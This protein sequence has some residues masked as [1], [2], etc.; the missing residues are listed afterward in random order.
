MRLEIYQID[1]FASAPFTGNPAAVMPLDEWPETALLQKLA[2]ENNLSETAFLVAKAEGRYELRWFTPATEVALCGHATLASAH[3]LFAEKG[4]TGGEIIFETR[5][6]GE[7]KVKKIADERYQMDLPSYDCTPDEKADSDLIAKIL[8]RKPAAILAGEFPLV[9]FDDPAHVKNM[10]PDFFTMRQLKHHEHSGSLLVTAPGEGQYDF[11][12]RFFAPGL[13]IEE[14]PVTGSAHCQL[15]P[16]WGARLGKKKLSAFQASPRGGEIDCSL[17]G[18]RV[19]L[20][21]SAV[22]FLRGEVII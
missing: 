17:A 5:K 1:A 4:F 10:T 11:I 15:A 19:H 3:F 14:D 7:L 8:G 16:F 13:G 2:M 12:S 20:T 6:S 18:T 22:T 9:V 21:G